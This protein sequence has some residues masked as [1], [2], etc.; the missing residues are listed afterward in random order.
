VGIFKFDLLTGSVIGGVGA[1][2]IIGL[3][4]QLFEGGP[5]PI[6]ALV[7]AIAFIFVYIQIN[8]YELRPD[9][10]QMMLAEVWGIIIYGVVFWAFVFGKLRWY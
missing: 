4:W 1:W 9:T 5:I 10:I 8:R 3:L 7:G 2:I 6:A